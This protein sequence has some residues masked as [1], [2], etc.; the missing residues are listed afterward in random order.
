MMRR[1]LRNPARPAFWASILV[2]G[3]IVGVESQLR[4]GPALQSGAIS[5]VVSDAEARLP[6]S[7]AVVQLFVVGA[8]GVAQQRGPR[9]VTDTSGRFVFVGLPAG[10][11]HVL[12]KAPGYFDG[13]FGSTAGSSV[14]GRITLQDKQWVQDAQVAMWKPAAISGTVRDDRGE[15][16]VDIPVRIFSAFQ[17]GGRGHWAA[18]ATTLTDDR[19]EYRFSGLKPGQYVVL[20][21]SIQVTLPDGEVSLYK[22]ATSAMALPTMRGTDG[23]G[24]M[25]GHFAVAPPSAGVAYRTTFY[26]AASALPGADQIKLEFGEHRSGTDVTLQPVPTARVSGSV[27]G[28]PS[29][30]SNLP[31]RLLATGNESLGFGAETALTNTDATGHFALNNVPTGDYTLIVGR[32]V[33]E[34]RSRNLGTQPAVTPTGANPFLQSYSGSSVGGANDVLLSTNGM[35]GQDATGRLS[36]SVGADGVDGVVVPA[37]AGVVVAGR[38]RLDGSD[39]PPADGIV[40][41]LGPRIGLEPLDELVLHGFRHSVPRPRP[42]DLTFSIPDVPPGRYQVVNGGIEGYAIVRATWNGRDLFEQPIEVTGDDP[43]DGIVIDLSSKKTGVSGTVRST[44]GPSSAVVYVFPRE[45]GRWNAVG[46][47]ASLFRVLEVPATGVFATD[48]MVPGDYLV[49]AL[50]AEHLRHGIDQEVLGFL[51]DR[52][53]RVSVVEGTVSPLDLRVIEWR[54]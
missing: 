14:T 16:Q 26:P 31:V 46:I 44:D 45:R 34:F 13:A 21:P 32:S 6:V 10:A 30:I 9:Q 48:D 38:V 8:G 2:L 33:A 28:P 23:L 36:V 42:S 54:R 40:Q 1:L 11:Y 24:T 53:T 41:V 39:T 50:S 37:K 20:V 5:G 22:R 15:S 47:R 19:G 52:A 49:A 27:S 25:V 43:I 51:A 17:V 3:L 12:V 18:S 35:A 29:A 7:G 4:A